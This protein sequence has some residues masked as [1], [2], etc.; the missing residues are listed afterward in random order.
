MLRAL[1]TILRLFAIARSQLSHYWRRGRVERA[2][3]ARVMVDVPTLTDQDLERI[4]ELAGVAGVAG[5][6]RDAMASLPADQRRAVEL[7][8]VEDL[9][10]EELALTLNVSQQTARARVSRGLRNLGDALRRAEPL[11]ED[12]V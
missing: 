7:R 2:A 3:L 12:I 8:V 9:G 5:E 6:L 4:E 1:R 10:Y 11:V